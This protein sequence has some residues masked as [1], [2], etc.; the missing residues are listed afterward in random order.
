MKALADD[1]GLAY[2]QIIP[3]CEGINLPVF[4]CQQQHYPV[5]G[6][7]DHRL[8]KTAGLNF[9]TRSLYSGCSLMNLDTAAQLTIT[10]VLAFR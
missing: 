8:L 3:L 6:G 9:V 1:L 5:Q 4:T 2:L 10:E 7:G